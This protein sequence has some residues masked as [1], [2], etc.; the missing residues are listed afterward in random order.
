MTAT[1]FDSNA[2]SETPMLMVI[3]TVPLVNAH[4]NF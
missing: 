4:V 1:G 3:L 2:E